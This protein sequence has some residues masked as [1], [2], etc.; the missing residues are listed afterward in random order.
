[1][2]ARYRRALNST[3]MNRGAVTLAWG[4]PKVKAP[5][6]PL[7]LGQTTTYCLLNTLLTSIAAPALVLG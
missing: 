3:P 1:M 6:P 2:R 4:V 5:W 7:L